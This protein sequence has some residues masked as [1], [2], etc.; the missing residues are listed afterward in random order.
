VFV[1]V[2]TGE[3]DRPTLFLVDQ[4]INIFFGTRRA[5]KSVA[6]A[7][8]AARRKLLRSG[9]RAREI[10]QAVS[11]GRRLSSGAQAKSCL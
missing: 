1:R 4:R 11:G 2:Y 9:Q 10:G 5:M 3:K 8:V 7:E 6:A